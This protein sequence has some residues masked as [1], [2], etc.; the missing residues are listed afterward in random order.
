[1]NFKKNKGKLQKA[2][3]IFWNILLYF[4]I[5]LFILWLLESILALI[6]MIIKTNNGYCS[7]FMLKVIEIEN[8]ALKMWAN[9]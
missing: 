8:E 1:M 7:P 2:I 6:F 3:N 4:F 5:I 9:S